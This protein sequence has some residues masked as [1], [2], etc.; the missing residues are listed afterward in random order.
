VIEALAHGLRV[1]ITFRASEVTGMVA[2]RAVQVVSGDSV[3]GV[4]GEVDPEISRRFG[5]EVD[6]Y[7]FEIPLAR[8]LP[9]L[10]TAPG[11][12]PYSRFPAVEQD[13]AVVVDALIEAEAIAEV[14]RRGRFVVDARPFDVY[15][16]PP[17]PA[18]R[19]SVAFAVRYQ[20]EDHTLTEDEV[21]RS[22]DRI[23]QQLDRALGARLREA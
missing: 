3:L 6:A 13:L 7:L 11:Y 19:K 20:A 1:P 17:I 12:K 5:L 16:G 22:R 10:G 14:I 8:L 18:G 2:G 15:V 4:A 9:L 21:A 23:V